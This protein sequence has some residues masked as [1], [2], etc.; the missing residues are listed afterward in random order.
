MGK[1]LHL[2]CSRTS[3]KHKESIGTFFVL[4]CFRFRIVQKK[5]TSE[6]VVHNTYNSVTFL[7]S[8]G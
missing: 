7:V 8:A 1:I 2:K 6:S 4:I 3:N 5:I